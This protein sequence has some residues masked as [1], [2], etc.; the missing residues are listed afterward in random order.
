MLAI[1]VAPARAWRAAGDSIA[2][3]SLPSSTATERPGS[4]ELVN[5]A[6]LLRK[7][8]NRPLTSAFTSTLENSVPSTSVRGTMPKSSPLQIAAATL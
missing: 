1:T 2:F 4:T 7:Q 5:S 3:A 8:S 6:S